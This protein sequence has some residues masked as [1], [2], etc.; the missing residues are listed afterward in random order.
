MKICRNLLIA[1][2]AS[3]LSLTSLWADGAE[4][5]VTSTN[6]APRNQFGQ[7]ARLEPSMIVTGRATVTVIKN[8]P[9]GIGL[10]IG[11][12]ADSVYIRQV[13]KGT[14]A[15]NAGVREGDVI[16]AI[17]SQT[18]V[19][20]RLRDVALR[21]RGEVGSEVD[22]TLARPFPARTFKVTL[23]R[24]VVKPPQDGFHL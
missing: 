23:K 9:G 14:P 18:T 19:G 11:Q 8:P 4:P 15:W 24:E 1:W 13:V 2:A 7:F 10:L 22:V 5:T 6:E 3:F 17:E 12:A 20:M 16:T 21:L